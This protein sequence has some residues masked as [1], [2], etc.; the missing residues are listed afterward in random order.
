MEPIVITLEG[1][2][3]WKNMPSVNGSL[4]RKGI[5]RMFVDGWE[6]KKKRLQTMIRLALVGRPRAAEGPYFTKYVRLDVLAVWPCP[7]SEVRVRTPFVGRP[8]ISVP[9]LDRVLNAVLDAGTG[10]LYEDDSHVTQIAARKRFASQGEPGF[11]R[12]TMSEDTGE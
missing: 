1:E 4:A 2:P 3:V 11:M 5:I 8:K 10:L 6:P 12:V 9:D 7:A